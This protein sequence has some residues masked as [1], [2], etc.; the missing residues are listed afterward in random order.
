M[1][2]MYVVALALLAA[3][4]RFTLAAPSSTAPA[5]RS[6]RPATTN[7]RPAAPVRSPA[8][9]PASTQS[10][11]IIAQEIIRQFN[12]SDSVQRDNARRQLRAV[13][14]LLNRPEY[15]QMLADLSTDPELKA[16]LYQRLEQLQS[17]Q[18]PRPVPEL[19]TFTFTIAQMTL[20]QVVDFIDHWKWDEPMNLKVVAPEKGELF[21]LDVTNSS[22]WEM[23]AA[24]CKQHDVELLAGSPDLS[25]RYGD[26]TQRPMSISGPVIGFVSPMDYSRVLFTQSV[27]ALTR[28]SQLAFT[29]T[30]V[31]DPRL[32]GG[33]FTNFT[34][35]PVLMNDGIE[36]PL[37]KMAKP[38]AVIRDNYTQLNVT[39]APTG[40]LAKSISFALD[41]S[42]TAWS[43][44]VTV[45]LEP[46]ALNKFILLGN[47][48]Y[49]VTA[50]DLQNQ[51]RIQLTSSQEQT[52]TPL[53]PMWFRIRDADG[54]SVL[55][56]R[57]PKT[58]LGTL[59]DYQFPIAGFQPPY[60]LELHAP[61]QNAAMP[62]HF[63]FNDVPLP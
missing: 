58:A 2:R 42:L 54:K 37:E 26:R 47:H 56:G 11:D 33:R 21:D 53:G 30:F 24:L 55:L 40:N 62:L 59:L 8:S 63:V 3:F 51:G 34:I 7:T 41:T 12:S 16:L 35:G 27:G 5:S 22:F 6:S 14:L 17:R 32:V 10:P 46:L 23:Y 49:K 61:D 44:D 52:G 25:L 28:Q 18:T 39:L 38:A 57:S 50:L 29:L 48:R 19:P 31:A 9:N 1:K 4:A 15:L 36:L 13:L 20:T 60:K 45:T 43:G